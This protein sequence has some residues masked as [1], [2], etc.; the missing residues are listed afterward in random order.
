MNQYLWDSTDILE[1]PLNQDTSTHQLQGGANASKY[2][3]RLDTSPGR[4]SDPIFS[5]APF[6]GG[7][8]LSFSEP[9]FTSSSLLDGG[10]GSGGGGVPSSTSLRSVGLVQ[11]SP[12]TSDDDAALMDMR[13]YRNSLPTMEEETEDASENRTNRSRSFSTSAA[14]AS[15]HYA[16]GLSSPGFAS[17]M[18]SPFGPS[19]CVQEA[20]SS[21]GGSYSTLNSNNNMSNNMNNNAGLGAGNTSN[22]NLGT[23]SFSQGPQNRPFLQRK[24][25]GGLPAWTGPSSSE[26]DRLNH[27][28]SITSNASYGTRPIWEMT[29]VFQP[30]QSPVEQDRLDRHRLARRFSLAPSTLSLSLHQYGNS[31]D[32]NNDF[33][34]SSGYNG[35]NVMSNVAMQRQAFEG[36][37]LSNHGAQR[38]HSVAGSSGTYLRSSNMQRSSFD[39]LTTSLESMH[40]NHQDEGIEANDQDAVNTSWGEYYDQEDYQGGPGYDSMAAAGSAIGSRRSMSVSS[41]GNDLSKVLSLGQPPY[42]GTLYVVEFKAGRSDLFYMPGSSNGD[43][44]CGTGLKR[45]DLVI[46]EADRGKDLGK[47]ANDSITPQQIQ[48]LQAQ[49]AEMAAIASQQEVSSQGM[50]GLMSNNVGGMVGASGASTVRAP[51]E[52]HPKRIF[53]LAQPAEVALLVNKSHDEIKAMVMCQSKVR[54]KKL[55]MEVVDAEY[56]WDRRKLTFYFI[57]ERRIDFRELV[58]D[59]FKIYKT[60]IWMC[61]V[62]PLMSN[63]NSLTNALNTHGTHVSDMA[64]AGSA[65]GVHGPSSSPSPPPTM[66]AQG[67]CSPISPRSGLSLSKTTLH[68]P[69]PYSPSSAGL[70]SPRQQQHSGSSN[71]LYQQHAMFSASSPQHH[72]KQ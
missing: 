48:A 71:S 66:N 32:T 22:N 39:N 61:A 18:G 37:D 55:P 10:G 29:S 50:G 6:G 3:P 31:L 28:R 35:D 69:Y 40:L 21:D 27:R 2:P 25:S 51:K 60:R 7:R 67:L 14:F 65:G 57:A 52:I 4:L 42:Q 33:G 63:S 12:F 64:L 45:G 49:Q 54:Q 70:T 13:T 62:N 46:V 53:R 23:G 36:T 68:Q 34:A 19:T 43:K 72:Q 5:G 58:R 11:K 8:S 44:T 1:T 41:S 20:F 17:Y 56:Q 16:G 38:R 47:I 24:L 15:S 59:L 30:L 9:S 26:M